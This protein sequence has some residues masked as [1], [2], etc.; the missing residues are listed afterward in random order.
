MDI[1]VIEFLASR[2][3]HDLISPIGAVHNGVEFMQEMGA[4]AGDDCL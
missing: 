1:R 4:E 3:C 2:M